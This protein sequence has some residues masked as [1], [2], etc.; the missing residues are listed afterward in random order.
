MSGLPLELIFVLPRVM[1]VDADGFRVLFAGQKMR[2]RYIDSPLYPYVTSAKYGEGKAPQ[3][4]GLTLADEVRRYAIEA[5]K[6]AAEEDFDVIHAHD[7][8]AYPAGLAAREVSGKPLIV[9]VHATEY[10]RTGGHS[11][12]SEVYAIEKEGLWG[13]DRIVTVSDFTKQM[14]IKHY[15]L[16]PEKIDV[17]HNGV[18]AA[19]SAGP[20]SGKIAEHL[21]RLKS[22]GGQIVLFVGRLTLQKGPDY[23]LALAKRVLKFEPQTYFVVA[24][25]GDMERQMIEEAARDGLAERM[26]FAGFVR[27]VELEA[28]YRA[29]DVYVLPS[30]SEP[31]GITPLEAV[32]AGTP[33]VICKQSGV[34]EC[35]RHALKVDFWDVDEMTN[36]VVAL[37]RHPTMGRTMSTHSQQELGHLTWRAAAEKCFNIYRQLVSHAA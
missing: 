21:S 20:V 2:A 28:L 9:H 4:Y 5:R 19:F 7:W 36:Q 24:G 34:A 29:A 3:R 14:V 13:A 8:L 10:D 27:G 23:F 17:V 6:L 1:P 32:A 33:V 16:P 11:P 15:G 30:V 31:F 12:N 18:D 35:L 26:I 25:S 37:L 22:A